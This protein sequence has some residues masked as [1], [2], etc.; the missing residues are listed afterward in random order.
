[1]TLIA[2]YGA[3]WTNSSIYD[4]FDIRVKYTFPNFDYYL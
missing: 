2:P 4:V 3:L 1:M